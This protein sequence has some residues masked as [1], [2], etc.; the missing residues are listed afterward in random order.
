MAPSSVE[1]NI[2]GL[3]IQQQVSASWSKG[4]VQLDTSQERMVQNIRGQPLY[5]T[6]ETSMLGEARPTRSTGRSLPVPRGIVG[7][8]EGDAR[9]LK[10]THK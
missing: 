4:H 6:A 8:Q 2:R 9:Q 10:L 1:A 7:K 3:E 5:S